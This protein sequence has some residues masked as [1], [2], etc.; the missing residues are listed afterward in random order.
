MNIT[1]RVQISNR[2]ADL[3]GL[4]DTGR[5]PDVERITSRRMTTLVG[6]MVGMMDLKNELY[7]RATEGDGG[8]D[9]SPADKRIAAR[10]FNAMERQGV[11]STT[12]RRTL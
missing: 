4:D 1:M 3:C 7:D 12:G 2:A 6:P 10:A 9:H 8:Y 11:P 5:Y